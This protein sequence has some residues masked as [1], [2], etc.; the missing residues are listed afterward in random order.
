MKRIKLEFI[1]TDNGKYAVN[2]TKEEGFLGMGA[3]TEVL[4]FNNYEE[5]NKWLEQRLK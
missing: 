3:K 2:D 4:A 1:I 5:L